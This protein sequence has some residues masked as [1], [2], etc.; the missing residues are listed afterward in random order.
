LILLIDNY[1]SFTYNLVHALGRVIVDV[2]A[3]LDRRVDPRAGVSMVWGAV[4]AGEAFNAIPGSG[5]VRGTVRILNRDAWREAPELITKLIR[6]VVAATG[7]EADVRYIRGVPPVINDRMASAVVAGAAGA[8]ASVVIG[9]PALRIR[10]LLLAVTTLAFAHA[11][12]TYGLN[13]QE[14]TW[15][16]RG[17]I[18]R[19]PLFGVIPIESEVQYYYFI[20]A[21]LL[22]VLTAA[23]RVRRSRVG[24]VMI[25]VREN[26]QGAQAYGVSPVRAKLTGFAISGFVASLAGAVFVHHQ[27]GLGTQPYATEESLAVFTMVVIGGLGSLPGAVLGAVYVKGAQ[28]FLPPEV[29]FFVGGVGLLIVLLVL[30]DGLGSLFYQ[31]RD[32]Y[33]RVVAQRRKILV[34]SLFADASDIESVGLSRE[35]GLAFL[36]E[37]ADRMDA[38]D[39]MLVPG[40][41]AVSLEM[42][43]PPDPPAEPP[44]DEDTPRE[45]V[46]AARSSEVR[47]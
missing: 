47:P 13:P 31:G 27:Q 40:V 17:R 15:L 18:D 3:L 25:G 4:H 33:L 22:V 38:G 1:D 19:P 5:S 26:D 44:P 35:R 29:S 10:G 20:V 9:L 8:A 45:D 34:P 28:Y 46:D 12:A 30:P 32:A 2:P 36:R 11:V 41:E 7:A 16:P 23:R 14:I 43:R 6:D 42:D 39:A 24:R 37:M 21:C